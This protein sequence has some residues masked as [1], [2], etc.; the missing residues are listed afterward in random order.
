MDYQQSN[1]RPRSVATGH[2]GVSRRSSVTSRQSQ[3]IKKNTGPFELRPSDIL[4]ERFSAW[5]RLVKN[6]ITYFEGIADIEANTAKELARLGGVIQVPFREGNQFLGEGGVQD[7]FYGVRERTRLIADNHASLAKTVEGS[8]V[9]HLQ[10]LLTEVKAHIKNI[11]QDTGKL[12]AS[13]AKEREISTKMIT[14]L[15][16]SITMLKNTPMGVQ[17][18]ED[19]WYTNSLVARQ[20]QKQVHEENALQKSIIIMQQNSE[21]FEE[22]VVRAIQMAWQT[23]DEWNARASSQ[24]QETWSTMGQLMRSV[25]PTTEWI[26]FASRSEY[27]LDPETPL[28][29]PMTINYPGKD[30]PSVIPV[31]QGILERKK[32]YTKTYKESFYILTPA[33]YL[34]EYPSSDLSKHPMPELSLFLPECTLGAPTNPHARSHKFHIEG[35]KSIGGDVGHKSG[36]FALDASFTFRARSHDEMLEWWNDCKQLSKVYLT[37]SEPFDRSGPVPAAVRSAGYVEED[38][39]ELEDSEGGSSVEESEYEDEEEEEDDEHRHHA[40]HSYAQQQ[41]GANV[42][43]GS[44]GAPQLGPAAAVGGNGH[45][46]G[47]PAYS[48]PAEGSGIQVGHDGYAVEKKGPVGGAGGAGPSGTSGAAAGGAS[49]HDGD[50]EEEETDEDET[51]DDDAAE[52]ADEHQQSTAGEEKPTAVGHFVEQ[53]GGAGEEE[54]NK[55]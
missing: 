43:P 42:A 11:Q 38:E 14:D 49:H 17:A 32:R 47:A 15:A 44:T 45:N 27:L 53:L 31:H 18:K 9:Q 29:N 5:K 33:G 20:L 34:H 12:A 41:Q 28:R 13:V 26:A 16:R 52:T 22:G 1:N 19:P 23:F 8:I 51:E 46:E 3:L 2:T 35:K 4:I 21:H 10:K 24:V 37:A 7:I 25:A 30:D 39:D 6:L 48:A 40:S 50:D 55:A 54:K 36:L